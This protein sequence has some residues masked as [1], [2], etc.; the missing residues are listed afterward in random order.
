FSQDIEQIEGYDGDVIILDPFVSLHRCPENNNTMID[1]LV[2]QLARATDGTKSIE[3]VHH[4]RKP[5]Q[6]GNPRIDASDARGA[7][8]WSDAIRSVRTLNRMTATEAKQAEI[9]NRRSFFRLDNG[10][11]NYAAAW[12]GSLWFRH[13]S[14]ILPNCDDVGIV[15]PWYFPGAF[16]NITADHIRKVRQMARDRRYRSDPRSGEWIGN[17]MARV[18]DLDVDNEGE[19]KRIQ[20]ILKRWYANGVLQRVEGRDASRHAFTFVEP[21]DWKDPRG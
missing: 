3:L 10:K 6:A 11:A 15:V 7:S 17:A 13:K 19:R 5:A 18:L 20:T 12:E 14:I 2:K 4:S 21:G 9:D 16:A 1:A 8:A